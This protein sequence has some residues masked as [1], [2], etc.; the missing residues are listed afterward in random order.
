M[1]HKIGEQMSGFTTTQLALSMVE[2]ER[3]PHL[4]EWHL[5]VAMPL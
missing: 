4:G 2:T 1:H 3:G 5:D